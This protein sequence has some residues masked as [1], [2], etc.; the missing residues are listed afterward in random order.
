MRR[1]RLLLGAVVCMAAPWPDTEVPGAGYRSGGAAGCGGCAVPGEVN[2]DI[3]ARVCEYSV[4]NAAA[5]DGSG[6]AATFVL[7]TWV[8][9]PTGE[10]GSSMLGPTLQFS[11]GDSVNILVRNNISQSGWFDDGPLGPPEVTP[12]DYLSYVG[13]HGRYAGMTGCTAGPMRF[14]GRRPPCGAGSNE[15]AGECRPNGLPDSGF[16]VNWENMPKNFDDTNLHLH[17]LQVV[18]HLFHPQ[19]TSDPEAQY[20]TIKPPSS[21]LHQ[22]MGCY[23][24][25]FRIPEDHP[26]GSYWYHPHRHNSVAI[27]AWS[28]MAG[29]LRVVDPSRGQDLELAQYGVVQDTPF[30]IWDPHVRERPGSPRPAAGRRHVIRGFSNEV[31]TFLMDQTDQSKVVFLVNQQKNPTFHMR[32]Q[33]PWRF[34][35][36]CATT[37]NLAAFRI[38]DSQNRSV[39]FYHIAS[40]GIAFNRTVQK[41]Y[42]MLA[43]G[44]REDV[45]VQLPAAG[46]YRVLMRGLEFVQFFCTGPDNATL[47]TLV[48][49]GAPAPPHSDPSTWQFTPGV[50]AAM[51]ISGGDISARRTLTLNVFANRAVAP[52]PQFSINSNSY[53][54]TRIDEWVR[55]GDVEE[56]LLINPD[57][58]W[59]PFHMHVNPFAVVEVRS[60]WPYSGPFTDVLGHKHG[61]YGLE[62]HHYATHQ[63]PAPRWRDTTFLPPFSTVKIWMRFARQPLGP[64]SPGFVG[65]TVFH[66]HFLAHEDTGMIANMMI[67]P[68]NTTCRP[69]NV[70]NQTWQQERFECYGY[71]GV[72]PPP[73]AGKVPRQ[74]AS[75]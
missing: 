18:P 42:L 57:N 74:A 64:A 14:Y 43:G 33:D 50:P 45:I 58:T 66:C 6:E 47:A 12:N 23:C 19:G 21:P 20:I 41:D 36:L 11:P 37:E 75:Q 31:D 49:A 2:I 71:P 35:V 8:D 26:T 72:I 56:W 44:Q 13:D 22:D 10:C 59:H 68:G 51:S 39:P 61:P 60:N 5:G 24:Y 53:T 29:L 55:A 3:Q 63:D 17:G 15:S 4:A 7:R 65:K 73:P 46:E 9:G 40:D 69:M 28:G 54:V 34:R 32:P 52:F 67:L 16:M 25:K 30:V 27:Q 1:V 70:W 48:A 62:A 38:V